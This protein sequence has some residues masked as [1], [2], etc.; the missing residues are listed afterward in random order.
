MAKE[1]GVA[2]TR[3]LKVVHIVLG[4]MWL[5]G[6]IALTMM[7]FGLHAATDGARHGMDLAM[8]FVDDWVIIPGAVGSLLIGALYGLK[9]KWGFFKHRWVTVKWIL[10][11]AGIVVG[12]LWLGPWIDALPP[13]SE[14]L[15]LAALAD[16]EYAWRKSAN[17]WL[18]LVQVAALLFMT[19][20]SVLKPWEKRRTQ[21]A[22]V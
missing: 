2:G 3:W 6:A 1:F 8:V 13:M 11:V 7:Q 18:A 21:K 12:T 22:D 19:A 9:T 16:P 15:G 4:V 10:T 17:S 14:K 20:I 5:G